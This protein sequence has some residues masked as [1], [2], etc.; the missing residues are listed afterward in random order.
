MTR[1][2]AI[3]L[4]GCG[5]LAEVGYLPAL[6]AVGDAYLAA[7]ADPDEARR[8]RLA[9]LASAH[10]GMRR[11]GDPVPA[12]ASMAAAISHTDVDAVV[13]ASPASTHVSD[14]RTAA[15]AGLA[16]LV[17]KPP[18]PDEVGAAALAAL[19]PVPWVG[20]NRR[21]DPGT[22][23]VRQA[24][25]TTGTV[26]IDI[27]IHYR[28]RSWQPHHVADDA[29]LDLGPHLVDLARWLTGS[30]VETV[31]GVRLDARRFELELDMGRGR[32]SLRA[33]TDRPHRERMEVRGPGGNRLARSGAGGLVAGIS[34]RLTPWRPHPLVTSLTAQL[35]AFARAVRGGREPALATA[36]DGRAVM[37]A[38]DAARTC[39]G[40]GG[41]RIPVAA[42]R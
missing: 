41:R 30:E 32:A 38:L 3:A 33:A 34:G 8:E 27:E 6:A 42:R 18:A 7:V 28:R 5:R 35:A 37:A 10:A 23:A 31:L 21:F 22:Q 39:G 24:V 16:V 13:L 26:E 11:G 15:A 4:V 12:F 17:E 25:P 29:L 20:F 40:G 14:A 19:T 2:L 1:P 36:A 9:G